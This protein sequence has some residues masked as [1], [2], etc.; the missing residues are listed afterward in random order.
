MFKPLNIEIENYV[1]RSDESN[2]ILQTK[3]VA[4]EGKK[5]GEEY[6]NTVGYYS[7]L[8]GALNRVLDLKIKGCGANSIQEVLVAIKEIKSEI[9]KVL[10]N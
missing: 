5:Q 3:K 8:E 10:N 9:H 6:F 2:I 1:I 7:T 4:K